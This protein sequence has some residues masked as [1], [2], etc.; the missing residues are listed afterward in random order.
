MHSG[1]GPFS[2]EEVARAVLDQVRGFE[3]GEVEGTMS[4]ECP[5]SSGAGEGQ[6]PPPHS[7]LQPSTTVVF[8]A[9]VAAACIFGF[10]R[11]VKRD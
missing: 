3:S 9:S 7:F 4:T 2:A 6:E 1:K 8:V 11:I 5:A 10:F